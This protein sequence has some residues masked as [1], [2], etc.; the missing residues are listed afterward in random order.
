MRVSATQTKNIK[1]FA[2]EKR[3]E[4]NVDCVDVSSRYRYTSMV[5]VKCEVEEEVFKLPQKKSP[6]E[7]LSLIVGA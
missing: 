5:A 1:I 3:R 7:K 6:F 2:R 4:W